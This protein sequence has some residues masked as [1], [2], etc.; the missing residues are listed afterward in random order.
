MGVAKMSER[1]IDWAKIDWDTI[2]LVE[3]RAAFR[4]SGSGA[5]GEV[6]VFSF[7]AALIV[8]AFSRRTR[9]LTR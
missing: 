1:T 8:L 9:P 5:S 6:R 2:D 7:D 3:L 4:D